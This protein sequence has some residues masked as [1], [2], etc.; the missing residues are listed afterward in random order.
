MAGEESNAAGV[1]T[2][3]IHEA[4]LSMQQAHRQFRQARDNGGDTHA[5]RRDFQDAILTFYELV[6]PHLR[7]ESALSD[8]WNGNL[9][10][11][12][13]WDFRSDREADT[14]VREQGTGVYEVQRHVKLVNLD[15]DV[16]T[17]GGVQGFDEWHELLGLSW[18]TERLVAISEAEGQR[19][20]K[21]LRCA[22]LP[23]RE[24]DRWKATV[25]REHDQGEG[26]MASESTTKTRRE[27][28]APA[29]LVAA[30]RLLVEA[31][32]R[33]GALSEFDAS[34]QRT[35]IT[36]EDME[37]VDQWRQKHLDN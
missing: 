15:Q 6:R 8:Y 21:V 12:T 7:H 34:T 36:R 14:Y 2:R 18:D 24:L 9:P 37:K 4:Y 31:G 29:K 33:L 30:K 28:E 27:F 32:D 3:A 1:P 22:V 16:L 25:V 10:D 20:I 11:Y 26:F 19:Y 5:A 35:E 17:D 23:L 13:G